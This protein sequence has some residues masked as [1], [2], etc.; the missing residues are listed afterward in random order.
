[1]HPVLDIDPI[2]AWCEQ[3]LA[4]LRRQIKLLQSGMIGTYERDD[5][6]QIDTT[7]QTVNHLEMKITALESL[8][9]ARNKPP[10]RGQ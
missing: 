2:R 1:M 6:R 9:A 7:S 4:L 3:E 8:L 5:H 10:L